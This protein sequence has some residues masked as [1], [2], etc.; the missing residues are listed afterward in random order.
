MDSEILLARID[1]RQ[2]AMDERFEAH[3]LS[4]IQKLDSI[5][6]EVRKTN[7]RV[8]KIEDE[9]LPRIE[10]WKSRIHGIYIT[11][12]AIIAFLAFAIGIGVEL[13]KHL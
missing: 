7:G 12:G 11:I 2:K 10:H 13:S 1:E 6:A 5:L 3:Q 4:T 8:T 9:R